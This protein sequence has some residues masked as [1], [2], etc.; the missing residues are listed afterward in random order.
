MC[1]Y[2]YQWWRYVS[3]SDAEDDLDPTTNHTADSYS[4]GEAIDSV[5]AAAGYKSI[6]VQ[7]VLSTQFDH[8]PKKL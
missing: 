4:Q 7:R 5:T 1:I 6:P 8:E 2:C 3:A